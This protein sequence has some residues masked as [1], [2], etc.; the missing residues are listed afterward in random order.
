MWHEQDSRL[1]WSSAPN[2]SN[3]IIADTTHFVLLA[4]RLSEPSPIGVRVGLK[5]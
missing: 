4:V 2:A 3:H 1:V 5:S